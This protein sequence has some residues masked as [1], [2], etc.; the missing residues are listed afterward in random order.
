LA[1][2]GPLATAGLSVFNFLDGTVDW[3]SGNTLMLR[4]DPLAVA[5]LYVIIEGYLVP[6][7]PPIK[8]IQVDVSG[9]R[10]SEYSFMQAGE[11]VAVIGVFDSV[12]Q[13]L[14]ATSLIR[15]RALQP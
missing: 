15:G 7:A 8:T 10:Q 13:V 5:P 1:S 4:V 3:V 2:G 6:V 14:V 9:L 12:R 11:R